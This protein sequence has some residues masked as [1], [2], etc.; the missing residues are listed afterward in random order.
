MDIKDIINHGCV[1]VCEGRTSPGTVGGGDGVGALDG[2]D[3]RWLQVKQVAVQVGHAGG[4]GTERAQVGACPFRSGMRGEGEEEE[5]TCWPTARRGRAPSEPGGCC[6]RC[7]WPGCW[8][9][10]RGASPCRSPSAAG[11]AG[12]KHRYLSGV[13]GGGCPTN[14]RRPDL[15]DSRPLPPELRG[16]FSVY[17]LY[18]HTADRLKQPLPPLREFGL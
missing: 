11:P 14:L 15:D 12:R 13:G 7:S 4:G 18:L 9:R 1:C 8:G 10:R 2:G 5:R 17:Q 3:E 16:R 6:W